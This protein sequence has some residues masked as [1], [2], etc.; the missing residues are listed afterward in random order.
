MKIVYLNGEFLPIEK[1]RVSVLDRGFLFGDGVYE[2]VPVYYQKLFCFKEHWQRLQYS[3]NAIGVDCGLTELELKT[4]L[5]KL[6]AANAK[7]G[8]IKHSIYLQV[9]AGVAPERNHLIASPIS[10]TIYAQC[11][12]WQPL[13]KEKL[14]QGL[15]A[16]TLEDIRW[17]RCDIKSIALLGN[18]MLY[19]NAHRQQAQEAILYRDNIVNEAST[20][21]IFIVKD[22]VIKTPPLSKQL[23]AG[24]TRQFIL[25]LARTHLLAVEETIISLEQ[26]FNAD[27]VW[28]T[29]STRE[30]YPIVKIDNKIVGDGKPGKQW[31]H[32]LQLYHNY[33]EKH[34][35]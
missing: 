1:A 13:A 30:I 22:N 33:I 26:L 28:I 11:S 29:S 31:R 3:L 23:L 20:S 14:Q 24:I 10:A 7:P 6:I 25:D 19:Q 21:N 5:E 17:Q 16:I 4:L 8:E 35:K 15:T 18:V 9:T 2:V 34:F 27:E 12:V 32:M